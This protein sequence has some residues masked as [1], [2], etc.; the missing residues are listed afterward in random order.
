MVIMT[1]KLL[2]SFIFE[3]SEWRDTLV[4]LFNRPVDDQ[5]FAVVFSRIYYKIDVIRH[6][7][8]IFRGKIFK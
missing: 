2:K 5:Q 8:F 7:E 6:L 3:F 4:L 1:T